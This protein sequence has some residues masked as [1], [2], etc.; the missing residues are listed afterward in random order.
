M[1]RKEP[2]ARPAKGG[3]M[4]LAVNIINAPAPKLIAVRAENHPDP[5]FE[6]QPDRFGILVLHIGTSRQRRPP[7]DAPEM[8]EK[9]GCAPILN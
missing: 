9:S 1:L 4:R 6:P 5:L 7:A 2:I 3:A 8:N